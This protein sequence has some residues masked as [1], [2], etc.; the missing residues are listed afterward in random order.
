MNRA[1]VGSSSRGLTVAHLG[2][3]AC[4]VLLTLAFRFSVMDGVL[5]G[6]EN[7][8]FVHL[9][10]AQ[11]VLLGELPVR[12]FPE[13]GIPMTEALSAAAQRIL[14]PR[15]LSEAL[16]A[17][18]L[19]GVSAALLFLMAARASG[20]IVIALAV[21]VLQIAM[22]P[23]LYNYPKL[24]AYAVTIPALWAYIDRPTRPRLLAIAAA[25]A[26]GFLLRHDHGAYLAV[27][28]SVAV[29]LAWGRKV[30]AGMRE[31]MVLGGLAL[32]LVSPYLL[33]VQVNAGVVSYF[34]GAIAWAQRD[35]VR[36]ARAPQHLAIDWGAPP[37][38]LEPEAT[39][40]APRIK[41][42][43]AADL[44]ESERIAREQAHGLTR[45]PKTDPGVFQYML[46]DA[47]SPRLEA[48][49][50]DPAVADTQGVDRQAF[51]LN[52][53]T[54]VGPT[55]AA[56]RWWAR[57]RRIRILPGI[58]RSDNAVPFLFYC[59]VTLPALT[60]ALMLLPIPAGMAAWPNARRKILVVV[61]LAALLG[62]GFLRGSLASRLADVTV[63]VGILLAWSVAVIVR[64]SGRASRIAAVA[65]VTAVGVLIGSSVNAIEDVDGQ[66]KQS[67]MLAGI[68]VFS[69]RVAAARRLRSATPPV[70]AWDRMAPGSARLAHYLHDCTA[71]TDRVLTLAYTPQLFYLSAR[72]FAGGQASIMPG[73]YNS[74]ADQRQTIARVESA[75]VPIAIAVPEPAYSEDYKPDFPLLTAFLD[76]HYVEAGLVD[77]QSNEERYRVLVH[78]GL[79]PVRTYAPLGLPCFR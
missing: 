17:M 12:D 76:A 44:S 9:S 29:L 45:D 77:L 68:G 11:Q 37:I 61:V 58:L 65:A 22:A 69:G 60:V 50:R 34:R 6:F 43:W 19:L 26:F 73:F 24:L 27:A 31:V 54:I 14:G 63:P 25:L 38:A 53:P 10:R 33:F 75:R 48:I 42:R 23:R 51:V 72:G 47:S 52:D 8:Q 59:F 5:G 30:P 3:A 41:I 16:L 39:R 20:S 13:L 56:G 35:A 36:T 64:R 57:V 40:P 70:A 32:A 55:D 1:S 74:D 28:G 71:P 79:Q 15:L 62:V 2:I 18:T 66:V 49:V 78:R 67:G 4:L 7:D 46:P 21:A